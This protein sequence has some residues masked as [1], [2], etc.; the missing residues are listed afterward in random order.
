MANNQNDK[1][2]LTK[3]QA[4]LVTR[5]LTELAER[6]SKI[7]AEADKLSEERDRIEAERT[8]LAEEHSCVASAKDALLSDRQSLQDAQQQLIADQQ[9]LAVG[10]AGLAAWEAERAALLPQISALIEANRDANARESKRD[11]VI[12]TWGQSLARIEQKVGDVPA[13]IETVQAAIKQG[14]EALSLELAEGNELS[15]AIHASIQ[16][17]AT[18]QAAD[19]ESLHARFNELDVAVN[20]VQTS[21]DR[22]GSMVNRIFDLV[23][24]VRDM[25]KANLE[26]IDAV[27]T[28]I[29]SVKK[30]VQ[31]VGMFFHK[32][33]MAE[34]SKFSEIP[35][36]MEIQVRNLN[37]S[38]AKIKGETDAVV[39]KFSKYAEV[40][41]ANTQA[42]E[43]QVLGIRELATTLRSSLK[44]GV[45]IELGRLQEELSDFA[46]KAVKEYGEVLKK[47]GLYEIVGQIHG[48]AEEV[49]LL[50]QA[51]ARSTEDTR[52]LLS[53]VDGTL[54]REAA[55]LKE[56][57]ATTSKA[58]LGH[59]GEIQDTVL[60]TNSLTADSMARI[61]QEFGQM[62]SMVK[63]LNA[64][65][66]ATAGSAE[67]LLAL[68]T[69]GQ[70]F[71]VKEFMKAFTEMCGELPKQVAGELTTCLPTLRLWR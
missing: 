23:T 29:S 10:L 58:M 51:Q 65:L 49:N 68:G 62:P 57:L 69:T 31:D 42:F 48:V 24:N 16:G 34:L 44:R 33:V 38:I 61:Q 1:E 60:R 30:H 40:I 41:A 4:E 64:R 25:A 70:V 36:K 11:A 63:D 3:S 52:E 59:F 55:D 13:L 47:S 35:G 37:N 6:Q 26:R 15:T 18:R 12:D 2:D 27:Y 45:E 54:K 9:K 8:K 66:I 71:I 39:A 56:G 20:L 14:F 17:V 43:D 46:V 50:M 22:I 5:L 19:H 7:N 53:D 32:K 67:N 21:T 28:E